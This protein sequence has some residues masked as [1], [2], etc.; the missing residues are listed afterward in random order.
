MKNNK[1]LLC[2]SLFS[3]LFAI[4]LTGC[5]NGN[6]NDD[7]GDG[8]REP[9]GI[10]TRPDNDFEN[11]P[12]RHDRTP[13]E[14]KL[15]L[16]GGATFSDGSTEKTLLSGE[17]LVVG[18]DILVTIPE[19][20]IITG[21]LSDNQDDPNL[22]G[23]FYAG[24]NFTTLRKD[25]TIQP[26]FDVEGDKYAATAISEDKGPT[27]G[28]LSG[29]SWEI[30][31]DDPQTNQ[32]G[33]MFKDT[34][35]TVNVGDEA[36]KYFHVG[37]GT[38]EAYDSSKVVPAGWH[39]LFLSQYG[40][41]ADYSYGFT[42][43]VQNYGDEPIDI[44]LYQTNSS[45]NVFS[46]NASAPI[47]LEPGEVDY[48]YTYIDNATN[49]NVLLTLQSLT[50]VKELKVGLCG[51]VE[52]YS[53]VEEQ[54]LTIA[55]G[56]IIENEA[57]VGKSKEY[58][59]GA[60][61]TLQYENTDPEKIFIGWQDVN[62]EKQI[63]PSTF[64]MPNKPL[65]L[66]PYLEDKAEHLHTVTLG[67]GLSF[68]GGATSKELCWQDNLNLNEINYD[69]E[70]RPGQV[71]VFEISYN[72]IVEEKTALD[73][74]VMPDYDVTIKFLRSEVVYSTANGKIGL[75]PFESDAS[76]KN[77]HKWRSD[78]SQM[79][80]YGDI[81]IKGSYTTETM[82]CGASKGFINEEEASI[83]DLRGYKY[84]GKAGEDQVLDTIAKNSV[85]MMQCN[86]NT[87]AGSYSDVA[88]V[89]NLGDKPITIKIAMSQSSGDFDRDGI[90]EA[91]TIQPGE[92]AEIKYDVKF[93][94]ANSSE[95]V[96]IQYVGEE[97]IESM[98][99]GLFIY[100]SPKK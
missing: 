76:S 15:T 48:T 2:L 33:F 54:T 24:T 60:T 30:R 43:K 28:K 66:K 92:V 80:S 83:F 64:N 31:T 50:A 23:D 51:Y 27:Y 34:S 74:F 6:D 65:S 26:I 19:G 5:A 4:V 1:K 70:L 100:R 25:A 11:D 10:T 72:G 79:V 78:K 37:G 58:K 62:D 44:K 55:E 40:I 9:V 7:T 36:G 17:E 38:K 18:E 56:D 29:F 99:V 61:V 47:H 97:P 32:N 96:S 46:S 20:R 67:E 91:V 39:T 8:D 12:N 87:F 42:Y 86:H 81:S 59:P 13:V 84:S 41:A 93:P 77:P 45:S 69:K 95:M 52:D 75:P 88:T 94:G 89:Q 73:T 68:E 16:K 14:K 35:T 53:K 90:S 21:W 85:F 82:D 98:K 49:G 22:F 3:T 57:S 71:M 63:Y